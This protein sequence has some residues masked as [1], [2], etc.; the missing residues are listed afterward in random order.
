MGTNNFAQKQWTAQRALVLMAV[1]LMAGIAGGWAL[2][3]AHLPVQP[4]NAKNSVTPPAAAIG[5]PQVAQAPSPDQ[6]KVLADNKATPM[7]AKL[8]AD[9]K[10]LELLTS[11]GNLYYDAQQYPVAVDYYAR[12]LQIKPSDAAV[13]TDMATAY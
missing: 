8:K 7:I 3:A 10:N 4:D 1:C 5:A 2:R 13:R 11:I 6:L 12:A 9:P